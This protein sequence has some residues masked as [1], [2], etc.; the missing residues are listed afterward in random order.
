M[1]WNFEKFRISTID[2]VTCCRQNIT[3]QWLRVWAWSFHC[4]MLLWPRI[5]GKPQYAQCILMD[6][7]VSS[8]SSLIS[9][10]VSIGGCIWRLKWKLYMFFHSNYFDCSGAFQTVYCCVTHSWQK[11]I[12]CTQCHTF[13]EIPGHTYYSQTS[14]QKWIFFQLE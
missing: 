13:P 8:F 5:S 9:V 7:P 12:Q 1:L 4:L 6:L 3:Q 10:K 14:T 11:S 2:L